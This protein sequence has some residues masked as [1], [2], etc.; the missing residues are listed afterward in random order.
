VIRVS[1]ILIKM[2]KTA[3]I[4]GASG[5]IGC[6]FARIHAEKGD[7]LVLIARTGSK[8]SELRSELEE[9]H[10]IE[11][12]TIIKDLS[13]PGAPA[14]IYD[15]LTNK[16]IHIDYLINNAGF[17]DFGFFAESDWSK[18][19][20]M[21][22]LNIM[23]VTQLT[24]LFLKD[25]I[26]KGYGKILN[27]SSVAAFQ[28]GPTMSVYFAAKAFVLSFSEA[29]N[30]EVRD[31]GVTVTALCPGS[32]ESSFHSVAVG[33][34]K[35]LKERR[36]HSPGKVAEYGYN[37]MMKGKAVAVPGLKNKIFAH[38]VGFLPRSIAVWAARKIQESK[39]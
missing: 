7:N 35:V 22:N 16:G 32:T 19:E 11:I 15:E 38:G 2:N 6:E 1:T 12:H 33:N 34:K 14:E 27:V 25:M 9:K 20:N 26:S 24:W 37:A 17:G 13:L 31:K 39:F 21:I 28:P 10:T 4:T 30:N 8:L 36:M 5:G 29:V 3:L 18:Q 23:A